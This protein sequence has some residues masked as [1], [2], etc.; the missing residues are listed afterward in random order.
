[1]GST[2]LFMGETAM[3][4]QSPGSYI[5]AISSF[6]KGVLN[7]FRV[8]GPVWVRGSVV[9]VMRRGRQNTLEMYQGIP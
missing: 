9:G 8:P 1:M 6:T 5:G 2:W 3:K 7:A 4:I